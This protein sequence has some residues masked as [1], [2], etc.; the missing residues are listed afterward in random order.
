MKSK[1]GKTFVLL[2]S[3]S[4]PGAGAP[5]KPGFGLSGDFFTLPTKNKFPTLIALLAA[6][7]RCCHPEPW[8]KPR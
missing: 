6:S 2:T 3:W 7:R 4:N 8:R 5:F 1:E